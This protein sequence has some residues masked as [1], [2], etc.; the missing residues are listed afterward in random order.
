VA[1]L[2]TWLLLW[3]ALRPDPSQ[4]ATTI[5]VPTGGKVGTAAGALRMPSIQVAVLAMVSAQ[6]IMVTVMTATPLRI[7][8]AGYG[9]DIVGIVIS[10]HTVGMFA[11]APWVGKLVDR[12]GYLTV[13]WIGL[14][15]TL[16]SLLLSGIAP[17]DSYAMLNVGLFLLGLGWSFLFVAGSSMLFASAPENVRQVVEGWADSLIYVMVMTGSAGAGVL[18]G[19]IGFGFLN[20]VSAGLL[21]FVSMLVVLSPRLRAQLLG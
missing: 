10:T 13:L 6:V 15:I 17:N 12:A 7:E 1:F 21:L 20:L 8:D 5:K 4:V 14:L 11:F 18:M 2:I 19:A 16:L 9:L 3:A